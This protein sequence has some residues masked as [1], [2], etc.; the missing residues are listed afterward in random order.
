MTISQFALLRVLY[1][2]G[3]SWQQFPAMGT[4]ADRI[5]SDF[6]YPFIPALEGAWGIQFNDHWTGRIE[7][8]DGP[9]R[10]WGI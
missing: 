10:L 4:L 1:V 5:G 8:I 2:R 9:L 3:L 6:S 7:T